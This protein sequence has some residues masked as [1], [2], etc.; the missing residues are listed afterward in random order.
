MNRKEGAQARKESKIPVVSH[1]CPQ[2]TKGSDHTTSQPKSKPTGKAAKCNHLQTICRHIPG[3]KHVHWSFK[4]V[5]QLLPPSCCRPLVPSLAHKIKL[6]KGTNPE[7][8]KAKIDTIPSATPNQRLECG[9]P[10]A[11]K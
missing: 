10:Q 3:H 7:M 11:T 1:W 9:K 2:A 4:I 6:C 5:R 8:E